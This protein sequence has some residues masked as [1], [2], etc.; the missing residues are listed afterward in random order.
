MVDL[1]KE[2]SLLGG[3]SGREKPVRKFL[4]SRLPSDVS[5]MVDPLGNLICHKAGRLG[6]GKNKIMLCAHMDEVGLIITY[7]TE[8]GFLKFNAVG[9]IDPAVLIGRQV[10]LESGLTGVIALKHI[11]LCEKE[12]RTVIP[13]IQDLQIDIGARS[14][15]EAEKRVALGEYA[16]FCSSFL[17]FGDNNNRWKGK[18][19][20]DRVGCAVLLNLLCSDLDYDVDAVFSVQEEVGARGA[21][22]A[23]FRLR[24]DV[25]LILETTTAGDIP[26]AE[27]E[28]RA[29]LLGKGPVIPFMDKG[30][31]Y[32]RTLYQTAFSVAAAE[33]IPC[34]TK[35]VIA[36]GNDA[37]SVQAA[38]PGVRVLA[39]SV[40]TRYL[41]S[42]VCVMDQR[43]V[44]ATEAL[45]RALLPELAKEER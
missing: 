8:E 39:L 40:P 25:A 17:T 3:I 7:I 37:S 21:G 35:T 23:A 34:Q 14:G 45:L 13:K 12:E 16:C 36:G 33:G 44:T 5:Y 43:D 42:P 4:I 30:T 10:L 6:A 1:V 41:H 28:K 2:L 20:D 18:A 29:C 24:P 9:G 32:D 27:E 31:L 38:G 11:H 19:L 15:E 26:G 22:A